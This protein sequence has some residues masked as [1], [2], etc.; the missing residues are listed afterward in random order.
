MPTTNSRPPLAAA[1]ALALLLLTALV[2]P[3]AAAF[4]NGKYLYT[5]QT[6]A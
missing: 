3:T 4:F 5:G 2:S 1:T 6:G